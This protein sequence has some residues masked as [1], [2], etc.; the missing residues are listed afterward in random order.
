[1][2]RMDGVV[3]LYDT[4][5]FCQERNESANHECSSSPEIQLV[6]AELGAESLYG[7]W[8]QSMDSNLIL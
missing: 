3:L 2:M 5:D 7:G 8:L 4:L 1:M 6:R